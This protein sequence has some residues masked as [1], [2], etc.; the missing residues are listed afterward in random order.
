MLASDR[1]LIADADKYFE[2][3]FRPDYLPRCRAVLC[4][5]RQLAD[6]E[7]PYIVLY[8]A[9]VVATSG[10]IGGARSAAAVARLNRAPAP[11][12]LPVVAALVFV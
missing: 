7:R 4:D 10:T 8:G 6:P 2:E 9:A 5:L 11:R 1:A 12:R 3:A